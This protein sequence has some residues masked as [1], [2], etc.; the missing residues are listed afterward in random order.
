MS[1]LRLSADSLNQSAVERVLAQRLEERFLFDHG[2][3]PSPGEV[4][5]W[6]GSLPV[7]AADL[8]DAGL[9]QVEVLLNDFRQIT[10]LLQVH[11]ASG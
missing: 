1:L 7:L 9:G 3:R 6:A 5:S 11:E 10:Q 2:H 8:C 4:R